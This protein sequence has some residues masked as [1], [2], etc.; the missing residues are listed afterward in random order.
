MREP[1]PETI[2]ETIADTTRREGFAP[3]VQATPDSPSSSG[4][5][6]LVDIRALAVEL[7]S[8]AESNNR[9][10]FPGEPTPEVL[11]TISRLLNNPCNNKP[12][13]FR[14][15]IEKLSNGWTSSITVKKMRIADGKKINGDDEGKLPKVYFSL[16]EITR[17]RTWTGE[18]WLEFMGST[19]E[20]ALSAANRAKQQS[21]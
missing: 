9:R 20:T 17:G 1:I 13:A 7:N 5:N 14:E 8:I 3:K 2:P 19:V 12:Q 6:A 15:W 21:A 18:L 10:L 16:D 11:S 4:A